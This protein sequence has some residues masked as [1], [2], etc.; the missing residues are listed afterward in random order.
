MFS[1][2]GQKIQYV[3][4]VL[5]WVSIGAGVLFF[6][7]YLFNGFFWISLCVPVFLILMW[8][9]TLMI[10]GFG[11]LVHNSSKISASMQNIDDEDKNNENKTSSVKGL[12]K[13]NN[14]KNNT[15]EWQKSISGLSDL[16]LLKRIE[17]K[18]D[19]QDEYILLCKKEIKRRT[20][21]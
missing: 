10:Y 11:V 5:F 13:N 17:S 3:A 1:N 12:R 2:P 19:W 7:Y 9:G 18:D 16:E 14:I 6:L 8:L 4:V 21:E 20:M 15:L